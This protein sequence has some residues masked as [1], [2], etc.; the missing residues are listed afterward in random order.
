MGFTLT[1][2]TFL[3][4]CHLFAGL[5]ADALTRLAEKFAI[6]RFTPGVS[7]IKQGQPITANTLVGGACIA[8][9]FKTAK[10]PPFGGSPMTVSKSVTLQ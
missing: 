8:G 7:I 6:E 5:A 3:K 4:K 2:C 1:I 9:A 10:V